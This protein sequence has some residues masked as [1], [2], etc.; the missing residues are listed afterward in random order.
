MPLCFCPRV[1]VVFCR[2]LGGSSSVN[3]QNQGASTE[4]TE[5]AKCYYHRVFENPQQSP[6]ASQLAGAALNER[7]KQA[8]ELIVIFL[9]IFPE[10][11]LYLPPTSTQ[12]PNE[13]IRKY[14]ISLSSLELK[15]SISTQSKSRTMR[16]TRLLKYFFFNTLY[17]VIKTFQKP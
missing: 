1:P 9:R 17:S 7:L 10:F 3:Q 14:R 5:S 12:E 16:C 2:W 15:H 8:L 13:M 6:S 11:F 4:I